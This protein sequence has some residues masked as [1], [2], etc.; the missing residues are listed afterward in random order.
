VFGDRVRVER[1]E[2]S[3]S[4][5][6]EAS[7]HVSKFYA[8]LVQSSAQPEVAGKNSMYYVQHTPS[9]SI[10]DIYKNFLIRSLISHS[11]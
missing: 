10:T 3:K 7:T 2:R 5:G 1:V 4:A 6:A 11:W 9:E 8:D